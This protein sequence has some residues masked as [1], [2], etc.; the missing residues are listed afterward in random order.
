[1]I[2]LFRIFM[3]V[4]LA[5]CAF[6]L[7]PRMIIFGLAYRKHS[8]IKSIKYIFIKSAAATLLICD[9]LYICLIYSI[10]ANFM[11]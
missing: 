2:D 9:I 10:V 7:L 1:M 4:L 11:I 8:E 3:V 5:L 6:F